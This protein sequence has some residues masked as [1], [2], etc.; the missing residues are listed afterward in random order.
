M[1]VE[2]WWCPA[3]FIYLHDSAEYK[4]QH[5]LF[6]RHNVQMPIEL[7]NIKIELFNINIKLFNI[8]IQYQCYADSRYN[9]NIQIPIKMYRDQAFY[10]NAEVRSKLFRSRLLAILHVLARTLTSLS[11]L[12]DL[13]N[14]KLKPKEHSSKSFPCNSYVNTSRLE[15]RNIMMS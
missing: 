10:L 14:W 2:I 15:F 5:K 8:K 1:R 7:F 9:V 6:I 3:V 11:L 13:V 4:S 12:S